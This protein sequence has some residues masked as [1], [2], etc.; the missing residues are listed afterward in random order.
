MGR[1]ARRWEEGNRGDL[2]ARDQDRGGISDDAEEGEQVASEIGRS[3]SRWP[4]EREEK[5]VAGV[6]RGRRRGR[7]GAVVNG[8]REEEEEGAVVRGIWSGRGRRGFSAKSP[9]PLSNSA[10]LGVRHYE[11]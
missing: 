11:T 1:G 10:P 5:G 2:A 7:E 3:R 8:R 4:A 9:T 6:V